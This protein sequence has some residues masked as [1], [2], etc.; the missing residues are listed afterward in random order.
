[1]PPPPSHSSAKWLY[2]LILA[3]FAPLLDLFF[4]EIQVRGAWRVPSHGAVIIVAAPHANQFVDS[5]VLMRTMR[6]L[7]RR[8]SWL[9]AAKSFDK[10][11]IG[12]LATGIGAVPVER[13]MDI[14]KS[15]V[16]TVF[17]DPENSR[18]LKGVGTDF[19][20][21]GFEVGGSV[22]VPS[23]N[24]ESHKLHIAEI[25]GPT[26][27]LI[28]SA[29]RDEDVLKRLDGP[30]GSGFKVAHH[31]DQTAVFDAVFENLRQNGCIGIFPEG[32]S[33][34]RPDLLPLKG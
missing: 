4:R 15:A 19:G 24:G 34:D 32:G 23:A 29:P 7:H 22:Y 30:I 16:G 27:I 11:I 33:H 20:T 1:M 3:I 31:V 17:L 13:A 10:P 6:S 26:E 8:V 12:T 25:R 21:A 18:L 2:D 28:K 9:M 14:M 5:L